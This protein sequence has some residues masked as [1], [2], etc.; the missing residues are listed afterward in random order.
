[1][2]IHLCNACASLIAAR[3]FLCDFRF[4]DNLNLMEM[5]G[6]RFFLC[7]HNTEDQMQAIPYQCELQEDRTFVIQFPEDVLHGKHQIIV[8]IYGKRN[9]DKAQ[10][11]FEVLLR[12]T[13][14]LWQHK[15]GLEYQIGLRSEL[16]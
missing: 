7:S 16:E 2:K 4:W 11:D 5:S 14:G 15:D 6:S 13:S 8:M 3:K 12:R 9:A 1:V 10:D